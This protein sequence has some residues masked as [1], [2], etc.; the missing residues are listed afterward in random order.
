MLFRSEV[1]YR[2][3]L[4]RENGRHGRESQVF[5]RERELCSG[6][7]RRFFPKQRVVS[8]RNIYGP[9]TR[10]EI[11]LEDRFNSQRNGRR[12][13]AG[14]STNSVPQNTFTSN[15]NG[16]LNHKPPARRAVWPANLLPVF[17]AL[18]TTHS[19]WHERLGSLTVG[20]RVRCTPPGSRC[21][22]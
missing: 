3:A 9:G 7:W 17:W 4:S 8:W 2:L 6:E 21:F 15:E 18:G 5:W 20:H 16:G 14:D 19:S 12:I 11:K 1:F 10:T 13:S 22:S